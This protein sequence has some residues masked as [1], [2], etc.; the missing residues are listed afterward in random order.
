MQRHWNESAV[1]LVFTDGF[2]DSEPSSL[3]ERSG[4]Q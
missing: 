1:A 2:E 3:W 4:I